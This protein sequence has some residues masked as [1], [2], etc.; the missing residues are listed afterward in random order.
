MD[1]GPGDPTAQP[2]NQPVRVVGL[3]ISVLLGL[4]F[5][6]VRQFF[7]WALLWMFSASV[8]LDG[9]GPPLWLRVLGGFG[10]LLLSA[11]AVL[12]AYEALTSGVAG[13]HVKPWR[14][15]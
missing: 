9:G 8:A 3:V 15:E 13:R 7:L 10:F 12:A 14:H 4:F 11:L 6:G 5:G 1:A 2:D